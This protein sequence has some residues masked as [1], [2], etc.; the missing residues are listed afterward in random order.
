MTTE[1]IYYK[2][3]TGVKTAD[4]LNRLT[5]DDEV[6]LYTVSTCYQI[7]AE[8]DPRSDFRKWCITPNPL[9][10]PRKDEG[11]GYNSPV[12]WSKG[13]CSKLD[14]A[15]GSRDL[16][17]K[18][19]EGIEALSQMMAEKYDHTIPSIKFKD[20]VFAKQSATATNF[21]DLFRKLK[22]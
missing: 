12:S 10:P 2:P 11:S 21:A 6:W 4:V 18:H 15:P 16:S 22:K 17:P 9:L 7:L 20:K 1:T 5:P 8:W 13:I 3:R 19:I 14:Q